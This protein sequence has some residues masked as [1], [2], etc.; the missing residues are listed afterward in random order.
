MRY[1]LELKQLKS[2]GGEVS[3]CKFEAPDDN[4]AE[5]Q[6]VSYFLNSG[7]LFQGLFQ[8]GP[9]GDRLIKIPDCLFVQ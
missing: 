9:R 5:L 1:R 8:L 2:L 7:M 6:A 4:E 3:Q